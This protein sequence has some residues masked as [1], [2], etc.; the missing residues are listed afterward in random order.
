MKTTAT[1]IV[2]KAVIGAFIALTAIGVT[3]LVLGIVTGSIDTGLL[4]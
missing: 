1:E 2:L 3:S 4:S